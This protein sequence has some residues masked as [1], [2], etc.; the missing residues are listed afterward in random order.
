MPT[1]RN[2]NIYT[3]HDLPG[4]KRNKTSK[5]IT[6]KER[7]LLEEEFNLQGS[8]IS[9]PNF[10]ENDDQYRE[11]HH[12][13]VTFVININGQ[14]DP[15]FD[16]EETIKKELLDLEKIFD[17]HHNE[18]H[19]HI[20][21]GYVEK[22]HDF[23]YE[24]PI[25]H[26]DNY[27]GHHFLHSDELCPDY[28]RQFL[29]IHY[30]KHCR[31]SY[32]DKEYPWRELIYVEKDKDFGLFHTEY[33]FYNYIIDVKDGVEEKT[34]KK[35]EYNHDFL[36]AKRKLAWSYPISR[37]KMFDEDEKNKHVG[38]LLD[39][40]KNPCWNAVFTLSNY[41]RIKNVKWKTITIYIKGKQIS[42]EQFTYILSHDSLMRYH[43]AT[44]M[45]HYQN[46]LNPKSFGI[47]FKKFELS[48]SEYQEYRNKYVELMSRN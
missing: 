10:K 32:F 8:S 48:E 39:D 18:L 41:L 24:D 5:I 33:K 9:A 4:N 29:R 31:V 40:T 44:R 12:F 30:K 36:D 20:Q 37:Q 38:G 25:A 28:L 16:N 3:I 42:F 1:K 11:E 22:K 23:D 7:L 26:R 46:I 35:I 47:F 2:E 45:K 6:E 34:K 19:L 27:H 13:P 17:E 14:M 21:F 43:W 15:L